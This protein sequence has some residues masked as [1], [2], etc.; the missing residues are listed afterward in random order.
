MWQV[1]VAGDT[2]VM[3]G[4]ELVEVPDIDRFNDWLTQ[5]DDGVPWSPVGPW[6]GFPPASPPA[7]YAVVISY[8][9][10]EYRGQPWTTSGDVPDVS[11]LW[12]EPGEVEDPDRVY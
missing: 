1:E 5:F 11:E 12:L 10:D 8:V 4:V 3:D 7:L 6:V 2:F 9:E